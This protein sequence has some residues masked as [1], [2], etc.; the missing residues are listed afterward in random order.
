METFDF[1]FFTLTAEQL[2]TC[3]KTL[4]L[5]G[6]FIPVV[7][8]VVI[9][10]KE[11]SKGATYLMLANA[12]CS[13]V[14]CAYLMILETD[15]SQALTTAYR[16]EY[17][18][19]S[20]FFFF[21][22]LFMMEYQHMRF[23]RVVSIGWPLF[24]LIEV[25]QMWMRS[26]THIIL[27][28]EGQELDQAA[29]KV[30]E[31]VGNIA[32][33]NGNTSDAVQNGQRMIGEMGK[34]WMGNVHISLDERLGMYQVN[35]DGGVL[36]Y[37][38]YG[39]I[40][41][42]LLFLFVYTLCRFIKMKNKTER[43]NLFHLM[44]AQG[45]LLV[46]IIFSQFADIPFDIMPIASSVVICVMTLS[47]MVGEFFTVTDQGRDWVFEHTNDVFLIADDAY[48][49]LDANRYA[50]KLFP[51][52]RRF[53]K[54]QELPEEVLQLFQT[55]EDEVELDGRFYER[56]LAT[57]YQNEKHKKKIAGYSLILVDVTKQLQ[58]VQEAEAANEAKSA[59]L[60]NMSHEIRTPMNAIV[61]MTEIMLRGD[62]TEEQEE[63]LS[64]IKVSGDA[65]LNI[66]NDILD[67]SKIESGKMELVEE[68]YAPM[69]MI[70][71]LG[72]MF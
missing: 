52:L 18:G 46:M 69:S 68:D 30:S 59:F 8:I 55:T 12:A 13:I 65:L 35:M 44:L 63:Y 15:N 37:V 60:S 36:Y 5:A 24:E 20:L 1:Y 25:P 72:I 66:I 7:S 49:Y 28:E 61:G 57:L 14:N 58:L 47:V 54:N 48:G 16:M 4:Q 21:F 56:R 17:V 2:M 6:I 31:A 50:K 26:S 42:M 9:L 40:A 53:H 51:V 33:A 39:L 34:Q 22:I 27:N 41:S 23:S 67:F 62:V 3:L 64:N 11:Q 10:Q 29:Q 32:G 38:R 45:F 70:S 71:D 19:I 43:H